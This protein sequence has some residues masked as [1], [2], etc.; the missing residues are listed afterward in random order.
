MPEHNILLVILV[1]FVVTFITRALPFYV[2]Q[3]YKNHNFLHYLSHMMP[4]CVVLILV[5]YSFADLEYLH[6]PYALPEIIAA[7]TV[8]ILHFFFRNVLLSMGGGIFV[9]YLL[10]R[11]VF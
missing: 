4:P 6:Y 2:L 1:M 5:I 8:V 10:S 9:F 3:A 11:V 7:A